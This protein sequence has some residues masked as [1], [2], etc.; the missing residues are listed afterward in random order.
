MG[1]RHET[2]IAMLDV[3][4][5]LILGARY[6]RRSLQRMGVSLPTADRW[7]REIAR[8]IP[9]MR[10]VRAGKTT[11]LEWA[12]PRVMPGRLPEITFAELE[13]ERLDHE[14][15]LDETIRRR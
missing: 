9:W 12:P 13:V 2:P 11:W 3:I 6:S 7:I 10:T 5:D 8:V 4:R 1:A 15:A 14:E